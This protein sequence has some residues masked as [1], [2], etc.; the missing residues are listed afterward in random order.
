VLQST[1][2]ISAINSNE[3]TS[4]D[5]IP[6]SKSIKKKKVHMT[7]F[8]TKVSYRR[9]TP[10]IS[11]YKTYPIQISMI[12]RIGTDDLISLVFIQSLSSVIV[13]A[14]DSNSIKLNTS[15]IPDCYKNLFEVFSKKESE[16]LSS[17]RDHLDHHILLKK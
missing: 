1:P 8:C 14:F 2:Q 13:N 15:K 5:P 7:D 17:H 10:K 16:S 9:P 12:K 3:Q 6:T 4:T 11:I